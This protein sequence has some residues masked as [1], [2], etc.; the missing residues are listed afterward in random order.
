[1]WHIGKEQFA[2]FVVTIFMTLST[3]LLIGVG[4]GIVLEMLIYLIGGVSISELF[5]SHLEVKKIDGETYQIKLEKTAM[6][7]NLIDLRKQLTSLPQKS[8][9]SLDVSAAKFIDHT[10]IVALHEIQASYE[11]DGGVFK[12]NGL[13][14]LRPVSEHAHASRKAIKA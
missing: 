2:V 4:S 11:L 12:I 9:V 14:K 6:F 8:H 5:K 10:T 1:M 7:S 13:D 3:D